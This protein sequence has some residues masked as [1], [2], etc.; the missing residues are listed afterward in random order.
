MIG[1]GE[2]PWVRAELGT[3]LQP[4]PPLHHPPLPPAG[5]LPNTGHQGPETLQGGGEPPSP[6]HNTQA[7]RET[8][9]QRSGP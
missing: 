3:D 8:E 7:V 2:G 5:G 6:I 4:T 1:R 9:A